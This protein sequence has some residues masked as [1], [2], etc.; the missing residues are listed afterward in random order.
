MDIPAAPIEEAKPEATSIEDKKT[1]EVPVSEAAPLQDISLETPVELSSTISPETIS[2]S[3]LTAV[4]MIENI[5]ITPAAIQ[6]SMP[7]VAT[8]AA[9]IAAEIPMTPEKTDNLIDNL[10]ANES[11]KVAAMGEQPVSPVI[12]EP[13]TSDISVPVA[14]AA[15]PAEEMTLDL[16]SLTSDL[17]PQTTSTVTTPAIND[18]IKTDVNATTPATASVVLPNANLVHPVAHNNA[19]KKAFAMIAAFVMLLIV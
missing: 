14:P 12:N 11:E 7:V 2:A 10:V 1:V 19:K 5:E 3:E 6:E 4:P 8:E 17:T 15:A 18:S 16:D 9:P 13:T